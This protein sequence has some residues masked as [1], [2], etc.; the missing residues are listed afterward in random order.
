MYL[1][2]LA[3]Y[4]EVL[5]ELWPALALGAGV[6]A[7]WAFAPV[8]ERVARLPHVRPLALVAVLAV[9]LAC[10]WR[11]RW[12]ADDA[13]ISLHYARNWVEG[14]GLVYNPGERVEGYTNFLWLAL[15]AGCGRLGL[16]MPLATLGGNLV[17]YAATVA[18]V[19]RAAR[20]LAAEHTGQQLHFSF[21]AAM[22]ALSYPMVS[23]AT[24]GLETMFCALLVLGA[25]LAAHRGRLLAS[26]TLAILATMGH[27][28]HAL[29]YVAIAIVLHLRALAGGHLF[30]A[31]AR[32]R[33][34][35]LAWWRRPAL[36]GLLAYAAPFLLLYV[37][38]FL[39]RWSYYGD[40][41]PNTFYTKSGG[42]A[43]YTQGLRYVWVSLVVA[44]GLGALPAFFLGGRLLRG[45]ALGQIVAV[46][47]VIYL[48]Y[49]VRL[50]GDF[51]TGRLLVSL[52][53]LLFLVAELGARRQRHRPLLAA[54]LCAPFTLACLPT[55][56]HRPE[57]TRW[58]LTDEPTFWRIDRLYPMTLKGETARRAETL[59]KYFPDAG[60]RLRY[61][62]FEIGY[63]AWR[64]RF[65][66]LDIHG[67]ID[68]ELARM[69]LPHRGRPGHEREASREYVRARGA[70]LSR[71]P[72][73]AE[74]YWEASRLLLD[75][76]DF[77]LA[78][79]REELL[80]PL[81][82]QP[83][84]AFTDL[85]SY[86]DAYAAGAAALPAAQFAADL[87]FFDA[88]YFS[89]NRDPERRARL[90][91]ARQQPAPP[92]QPPSAPAPQQP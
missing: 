90:L 77:Y 40:P 79:H 81:R 88:Y 47:F 72:L 43:Y 33:Y 32:H 6:A 12:F 69:P 36:R 61:A 65:Y 27:P 78:Q 44:G 8:R 18:L 71:K 35:D 86:L 2:A 31:A 76:I 70:A 25:A 91:A 3:R 20:Q 60:P 89:A 84:V 82:G 58:Y 15:I 92:P 1:R 10:A 39:L 17:V 64:T 45:T 41:L 24:G 68:R 55:P 66:I 19:H 52:L 63:M 57:Q 48:G 49:V 7:G 34:P 59:H 29:F 21:A 16:D 83:G 28:D 4:G 85:P 37:P 54:L 14:H 74:P 53:P 22:T 26:G 51:M 67:L 23:F 42:A 73:Y 38:Y 80:A 13:F 62:V 46:S 9:G 30:G 5:V 11:M 56:L 75:G 50:G 87:E